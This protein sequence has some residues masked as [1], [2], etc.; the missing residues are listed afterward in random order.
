MICG[1]TTGYL[2]KTDL[3]FLFNKQLNLLGSTTAQ[4]PTP[5]SIEICRKRADQAGGLADLPTRGCC[6]GAGDHVRRGAFWQAG[7]GAIMVDT[8]MESEIRSTSPAL[9]T[10]VVLYNLGRVRRP[11]L[12]M[13]EHLR[14]LRIG[15]EID[16]TLV[17]LQH[18]PVITLG[19]SGG[20]ED[21]HVPVSELEAQGVELVEAEP[22]RKSYLSMVPDS[23]WLTR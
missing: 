21:L 9:H 3:R 16:D 2:P 7:T 10:P 23:S 14:K 6:P 12:E 19:T 11:A 13:Q 1:N 4:K 22:R 5:A 17:V 15:D 18:P 20:M 8:M